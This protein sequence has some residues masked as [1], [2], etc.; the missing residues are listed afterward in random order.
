[1]VV[2][3]IDDS[4][5]RVVAA[6]LTQAGHRAHAIR[7]DVSSSDAVTAAVDEVVAQHGRIDWMFNNAGVVVGGDIRQIDAHAWQHIVDIN[8]L[9]VAY[10]TCAAYRHMVRQQCG[11][12]VNIASMYGL[13]PGLLATPYVATK[14]AVVGMSLSLRPE[15]QTH[16]VVVTAVCP[17]FI[18]SALL[19]SGRYTDGLTA[20]RVAETIPFRFIDADIA[21]T[22]ILRGAR[23]NRAL[24]VFPLYARIAWWIYRL[25]PRLMLF[26]NRVV[27]RSHSARS[28]V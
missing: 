15:A 7:L 3:D 18:D 20:G 27:A 1:M 14:H 9:G 28:Q 6:T 19:R 26:I 10:G 23:N 16:G 25:S 21:A 8:F 4:S 2:A 11:H 22:K 17:G 13:F 5:A 24:V 12:I